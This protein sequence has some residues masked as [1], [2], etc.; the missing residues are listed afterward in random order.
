MKLARKRELLDYI[1]KNNDGT[2]EAE[3][4]IK[5][6]EYEVQFA[7]CDVFSVSVVDLEH[8][9]DS[10][11]ADNLRQKLDKKPGEE[12]TMADCEKVADAITDMVSDDFGENLLNAIEYEI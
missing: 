2:P 11:V 1:R 8:L 12:Y 9:G 3:S 7:D 4:L 6:L 10:E 5:F